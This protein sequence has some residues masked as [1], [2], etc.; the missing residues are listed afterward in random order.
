MIE[1]FGAGTAAVVAPVK[2][3]HWKGEDL[4]IPLDPSDN[5]S[6]AGKLTKRLATTIMDIQYGKV[7]HPWSHVV[8]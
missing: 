2:G 1:S 4:K 6:Q 7:D 5:S 8:E 3:I